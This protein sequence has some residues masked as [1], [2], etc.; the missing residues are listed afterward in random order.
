MVAVTCSTNRMSGCVNGDVAL[1][2]HTD[3]S[4]TAPSVQM[5]GI[6]EKPNSGMI[7]K[8]LSVPDA[9]VLVQVRVVARQRDVHHGLER[10]LVVEAG[11]A[12]LCA[13]SG[14][15]RFDPKC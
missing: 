12:S 5:A 9:R 8:F 13:R 15:S 10:I 4:S 3:R 14:S 2:S 1:T 7:K 6:G 11:E